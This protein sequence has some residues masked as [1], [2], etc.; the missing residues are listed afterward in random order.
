[1]AE[2]LSPQDAERAAP[3]ITG[4]QI[5]TADLVKLAKKHGTRDHGARNEILVG[6]LV[7]GVDLKLE[8]KAAPAPEPEEPEP[9]TKPPS[10]LISRKK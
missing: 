3:G 7:K 5:S 9:S 4:A 10:K 8:S 2:P 6:L 1:M